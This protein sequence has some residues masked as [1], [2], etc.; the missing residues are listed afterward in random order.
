MAADATKLPSGAIL[1]PP[2]H[3]DSRTAPTLLVHFPGAF[4]PADSYTSFAQATQ[5]AALSQGVSMCV[6]IVKYPPNWIPFLWGSGILLRPGQLLR[7]LTD[8]I[9]ELHNFLEDQQAGSS[10]ATT[11]SSGPDPRGGGFTSLFLSGHSLGSVNIQALSALLSSNSNSKELPEGAADVPALRGLILLGGYLQND[12]EDLPGVPVAT[13]LGD[14][15][16]LVKLSRYNT[17]YSW[18]SERL[19]DT[20]MR[21]VKAP[22]AILQVCS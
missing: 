14:R 5:A 6:C 7:M 18:V 22:L 13:I 20:S 15:D 3:A 10:S 21:A 9:S 17:L 12:K 2:P 19:P 1:L 11:S 4:C 8:A 16:G